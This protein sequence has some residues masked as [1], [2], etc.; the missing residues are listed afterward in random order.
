MPELNRELLYEKIAEISEKKS[1]LI[2]EN[3]NLKKQLAE[4]H[5][6]IFNDFCE[7]V[8]IVVDKIDWEK[9][10]LDEGMFS[11]KSEEEKMARYFVRIIRSKSQEK[12]LD[13]REIAKRIALM[14]KG[15]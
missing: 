13:E 4:Y 12:G 6:T 11:G 15:I 5:A 8:N 1:N 10:K 9:E 2:E 7:F 14:L 3:E